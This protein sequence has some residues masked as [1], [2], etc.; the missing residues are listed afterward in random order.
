[1]ATLANNA[2][3]LT[4]KAV[5]FIKEFEQSKVEPMPTIIGHLYI[6]QLLPK[7]KPGKPTLKFAMLDPIQGDLILFKK[8]ADFKAQKTKQAETFRLR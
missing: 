4:L 7:K 3:P 5:Q 1:M 8:A 2:S 6:L